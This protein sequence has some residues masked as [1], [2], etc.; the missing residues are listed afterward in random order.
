VDAALAEL[1][2]IGEKDENIP[3]TNLLHGQFN[4]QLEE[5]LTA[6][7]HASDSPL[8]WLTHWQS[9]SYRTVAQ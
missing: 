3:N 2:K 6:A 9:R 7:G 5:T 4:D 8:F 1:D